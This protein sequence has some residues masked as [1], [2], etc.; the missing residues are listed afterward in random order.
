MEIKGIKYIS[1]A[2]DS[3]GYAQASRG[4]ILSLHKKGIPLMLDPVSFENWSTD[5]NKDS[6]ILYELASKKIDYNTVIIHLTPEFWEK[7]VKLI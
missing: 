2:F 6:E 5:L 3:S 7:L 4:Y 1:P